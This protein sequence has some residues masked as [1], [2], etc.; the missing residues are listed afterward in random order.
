MPDPYREPA[1]DTS[2]PTTP[3]VPAINSLE[4]EILELEKQLAVKKA[5]M[6]EKPLEQI[7]EKEKTPTS[8]SAA[9]NTGSGWTNAIPAVLPGAI[10]EETAKLK[11]VEKDQQ[12]KA[13]V[14][15]AF[16]KGVAYASDVARNL[17][18]PYLMD[19]FHDTLIDEFR[20]KLVDSGKLEE[21]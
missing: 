10:Q 20:Q 18:N 11:G 14:D 8:Q 6:Q 5:A 4:R 13:L 2:R 1:E 9:S 17:D 21:I 3:S 7:L 15:L 16:L 19:E 12:L